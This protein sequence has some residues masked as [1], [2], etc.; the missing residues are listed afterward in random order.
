MNIQP[1]QAP[2]G[3]G[4]SAVNDVRQPPAPRQ[5]A[6]AAQAVQKP[7]EATKAASLTEA[8]VQDAVRR[9]EEFVAATTSE[10]SFSVDTES[11]MRVVKVMDKATDEVI[12]QIPSEE[13]V[14]IAQ[15]LD[16]LQGLFLRDKV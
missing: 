15:A 9:V 3:A 1:V 7:I 5:E 8:D 10:I 11:G 14:A 12:R 13:V 4:T 2:T 16:K 6:S